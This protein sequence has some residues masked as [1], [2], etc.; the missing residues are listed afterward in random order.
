MKMMKKKIT[1]GLIV[2]TRN[3]FNAQLARKGRK[4]LLKV[5][6]KLGFDYVITP[7][8]ATPNGAIET[9]SDAKK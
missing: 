1:F 6:K 7:E 8:N 9:L 2:A 5:I 3:T 4:Q